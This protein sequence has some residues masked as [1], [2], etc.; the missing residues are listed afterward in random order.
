VQGLDIPLQTSPHSVSCTI[1][2]CRLRGLV[3]I[4]GRRPVL[5]VENEGYDT[6]EDSDDEGNVRS[7]S[8]ETNKVM[9]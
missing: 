8:D 9:C 6:D 7:I 2:Q 4:K 5:G 3:V 1:L